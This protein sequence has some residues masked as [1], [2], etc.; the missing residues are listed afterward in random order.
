MVARHTQKA[1][2]LDARGIEVHFS[3]EVR[4][5]FAD[6]AAAVH[7]SKH[8]DGDILGIVQDWATGKRQSVY[9]VLKALPS[10]AEETSKHIRAT[11]DKRA[12]E[13]WSEIGLKMSERGF[14][15]TALR[16]RGK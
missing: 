15:L 12:E 11:G 14:T 13:A 1:A 4:N 10:V 5:A 6:L 3:P 7:F 2:E 8:F 9:N 16:Q